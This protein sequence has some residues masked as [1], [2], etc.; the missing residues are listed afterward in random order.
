MRYTMTLL[1]FVVF[2]IG[3]ILSVGGSV[4]SVQ[5]LLGSMSKKSLLLVAVIT[6]IVTSMVQVAPDYIPFTKG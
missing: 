1:G 3:I 6:M 2:I 5:L 4:I